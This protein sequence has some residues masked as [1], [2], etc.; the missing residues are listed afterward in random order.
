MSYN[1]PSPLSYLYKNQGAR[2]STTNT[3]HKAYLLSIDGLPQNDS[4]AKHVRRGSIR[5]VEHQLR[6]HVRVCTSPRDRLIML[7]KERERVA[8][9]PFLFSFLCTFMY[10][11]MNDE[12]GSRSINHEQRRSLKPINYCTVP[13]FEMLYFSKEKSERT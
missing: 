1:P 10:I 7:L 9:F 2:S 8:K 12:H 13:L 5:V 6:R 3:R 11:F 4:E